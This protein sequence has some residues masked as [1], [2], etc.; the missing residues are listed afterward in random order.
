MSDWRDRLTT[1]LE[2]ILRQPDPRPRLSAYHDMPYAIFRYAPEDEF[3]VRS[4]VRLLRTRLEQSGK[5]VTMVSLAECLSAAL[6]AE[7]MEPT[8]LSQAEIDVGLDKTVET[9]FE[10][11]SSCQPLD[12]LV[13]ARIPDGADPHRDVVFIVR[14]GSLFPVYRTSSLL[15][16]LKGKVQVPSVLFYPGDLEGAAGL[17]FMGVLDAEHNYRPKIF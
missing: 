15:D 3:A 16:Q 13:L 4:E 5:R 8:A 7:G 11:I 6:R 9:V 1:G 10:I 17:R 14:A 2:P 12:E